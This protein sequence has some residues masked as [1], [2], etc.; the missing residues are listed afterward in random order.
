MT[1]TQSIAA[2]FEAKAAPFE[3]A[4]FKRN[5][6]Q[7]NRGDGT[8]A[9][10]AQLS[11]LEASGWSWMPVF[12]DVDLDGY[13]DLLITTGHLFDNQDADMQ[14]KLKALGSQPREKQTL[15]LLQYPRLSL[16]NLAFR[17]LGGLRF[18]EVGHQWGFDRVGVKHGLC[19][20]DL[21]N[22]G[23]LDVITNDLN[24]EAGVYRN[25]SNRPRVA[26]R[27]KGLGGNTRGIGS[28]I[29]LYGGAVP[30]QSQEMICGGRYLSCDDAMR[31]FAAGIETNR[32]HL[33]VRWRSG[34]RSVVENVRANREYEIDEAGAVGAWTPSSAHPSQG[35]DRADEG[36]RAPIFEDA[37]SLLNHKHHEEV[38][39]D[40]AHQV[41]LPRKLS[42][43]G[44][45]VS[46][47]DVDGDG[48]ED[49]LVG[50]G[51]GS[52]LDIFLN[53]GSGQFERLATGGLL[54]RAADDQ[55]TVLGWSSGQGGRGFLVGQANYESGG[56]NGVKRYELWAGGLRP[57]ETLDM[58]PSSIGALA[59]GDVKGD[60]NLELFGGGRVNA[61][62][63][64]EATSS[65]LYRLQGGKYVL[66][67]TNSQKLDQV[68]MV[69]G[70]VFSDLDGDGYPEL[71]LACDWGPIKIFHNDHGHLS[72]WDPLIAIPH[73]SHPSHE[74]HLHDL[75]GWWNGVSV[76][77]FDGDGRLDIVASNWGRNS[78]YELA[79]R[80]EQP[81]RVYYGDWNGDGAVELLEAYYDDE[82]KKVVPWRVLTSVARAMPWVQERF[83]THAAYSVASVEEIL[84]ERFKESKMLEAQWFETSVFLNRGDHFEVVALPGEAQFAPAFGVSVGD[85]DGDGKED[86]FLSQ[87]FFGV[88]E[89]TTRYDA[90]RG[91][92][93]RGD[94]AGR[95][96]VV[97][98]QVSGVKVYGE[99]RGSALC[100]YDGD[101][102]VDLVVGQNEA[103]TKLYHNVGAKPGLRVALVGPAGNPTGIGAVIRL[104][105]GEKWGPAREVHAGS[106]Y[107]SQDSPVQV[108]A[109]PETPTALWVR[110]PGGNTQEVQITQAMREITVQRGKN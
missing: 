106:G 38:Y 50:G 25:E 70:A 53:R 56:T 35:A 16:P 81:L 55:V 68:G 44:P 39:D 1:Q 78:K 18:Q 40:F 19:C 12:L 67:E 15:G 22:D 105:F 80:H 34:K 93:L 83:T 36:V 104:R 5:V 102:R 47:S 103:G 24:D 51:R 71:I 21:D 82:L 30:V 13:E 75:T 108:M 49:L 84:G 94:G 69:S 63:W 2:P 4:Q 54:G 59:L 3:R 57:V 58:G 31:V 32:M 52:E 41:L 100:D 107:W 95:F 98:G 29:W 43:L 8:Y 85:M 99:G 90:G 109:T 73:E 76:G 97:P 27:L 79:L 26:V 77:D 60:G 14:S 110:W 62:R 74:S 87:N 28:K 45:G 10:V 9:D 33:E 23:D 61:G 65:R 88:D 72:P 42:Q 92:W 37:S 17:N 11:G 6:L 64:P 96:E 101:G 89:E 86:I 66:D 7:V 46:W 91:V 48:R 20:A